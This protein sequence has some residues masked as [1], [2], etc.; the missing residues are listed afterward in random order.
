M[1]HFEDIELDD[2]HR[3]VLQLLLSDNYHVNE[4]K[5]QVDNSPSVV[6]SAIQG[7]RDMGLID[8]KGQKNRHLYYL[9][10]KGKQVASIIKIKIEFGHFGERWAETYYKKGYKV[11]ILS[12]LTGIS[13]HDNWIF[14]WHPVTKDMDLVRNMGFRSVKQGANSSRYLAQYVNKSID[15]QKPLRDSELFS[16]ISS[17]LSEKWNESNL[18]KVL[19]EFWNLETH[20]SFVCLLTPPDELDFAFPSDIGRQALMTFIGV[21]HQLNFPYIPRLSVFAGG[22]N[23]SD[24]L[25]ANFTYEA[26]IMAARRLCKATS[27]KAVFPNEVSNNEIRSILNESFFNFNPILRIA[28]VNLRKEDNICRKMGTECMALVDSDLDF[29]KCHILKN[30][31]LFSEEKI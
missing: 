12:D 1:N 21:G 17:E 11:R 4:I 25:K 24:N 3:N 13:T 16:Y 2:K 30:D 28:C 5:K 9:T 19:K 31:P 7:L 29:S 6:M 26:N 10:E 8:F 20:N 23:L 27:K 14:A 15:P 22:F 18:S